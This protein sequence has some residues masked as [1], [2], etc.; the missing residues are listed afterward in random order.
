[1]TIENHP[2]QIGRLAL[3]MTDEWWI[4]YY[5]EPDTMDDAV[6][7]MRIRLRLVRD[8]PERTRQFVNLARAAT[9]DILEEVFGIR[10]TWPTE[11]TA[12]PEHERGVKPRR[13]R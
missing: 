1:M 6:E 2:P 3:R 13:T 11:P 10:P 8:K 4:A 5:A 7:L 12:A 9:G